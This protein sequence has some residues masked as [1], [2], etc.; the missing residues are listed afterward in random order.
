MSKS[1]ECIA[2][3]TRMEIIQKSWKRKSWWGPRHWNQLWPCTPMSL[4][5]CPELLSWWLQSG[6]HDASL[7]FPG[8]VSER[9]PHW[10]CSLR[11]LALQCTGELGHAPPGTASTAGDSSF[12]QLC[13]RRRWEEGVARGHNHN[14]RLLV[15]MTPH[16]LYLCNLKTVRQKVKVTLCWEG[17]QKAEK[18]TDSRYR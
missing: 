2:T 17:F 14:S 11:Q 6:A 9:S 12:L 7:A 10:V 18:P 13:K 1:F 3:L 5:C 15:V 16:Q 8:E 4:P